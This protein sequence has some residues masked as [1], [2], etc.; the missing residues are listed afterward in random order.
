MD[1]QSKLKPDKSW[2]RGLIFF[3][4]G[5]LYF[6]G[7]IAENQL[8]GTHY[9]AWIYGGLIILAGVW[10]NV[11]LKYFNKLILF[12]ILIISVVTGTGA[13]HYELAHHLD[14]IFSPAT[15]HIHILI[16]GI[17]IVFLFPILIYIPRELES[18]SRRLFEVAANPIDE[19]GNGFTARPYPAG[20]AKYTKEEITGFAKFLTNKLIAVSHFTVDKVILTFSTGLSHFSNIDLS[21]TSY[22]S[23]DFTGNLS[24]N[25]SKKDYQQYRAQF[26][27]DQLCN[28][29]A[30]L[31]RMFLFLYQN[32]DREQIVELLKTVESQRK[33]AMMI[34]LTILGAVTCLTGIILY[35]ILLSR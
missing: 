4:I 24:V 25:I 33:R 34:A 7:S 16:L 10:F 2:M 19:T 29:L 18:N 17:F 3:L 13:W 20:Q 9:S 26:T 5:I 11:K 27:F 31:F 22:I 8:F 14:T 1:N 12:N 35:F 15:F 23:F 28:S 30:E 32:G 21:A 6:F